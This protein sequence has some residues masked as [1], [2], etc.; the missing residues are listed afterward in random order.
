MTAIPRPDCYRFLF[1]S[2]NLLI[3][4]I[5]FLSYVKLNIDNTGFL[6]YAVTEDDCDSGKSQHYPKFLR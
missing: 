6:N 4:N 5:F 1:K 2:E 3:K